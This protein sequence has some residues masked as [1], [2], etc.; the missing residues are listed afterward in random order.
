MKR[1]SDAEPPYDV[2]GWDDGAADAE[3]TWDG[4]PG[5]DEDDG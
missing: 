2:P 4:G 3:P 5:E 1:I